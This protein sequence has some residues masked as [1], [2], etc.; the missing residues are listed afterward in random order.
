MSLDPQHIFQNQIL[1]LTREL[2]PIILSIMKPLNRHVLVAT[3]AQE[4]HLSVGLSVC[5]W[6]G[7]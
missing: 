6:V 2:Y 3:A 4:P 1:S 7:A 5:L